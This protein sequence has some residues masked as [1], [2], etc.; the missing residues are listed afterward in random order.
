MTQALRINADGIDGVL[1]CPRCSTSL[2]ESSGQWVC[3]VDGWLSPIPVYET[4]E[5]REPSPQIDE[6]HLGTD[7]GANVR[8][9]RGEGE[10]L[11]ES[12]S[13]HG[14]RASVF[15]ASGGTVPSED[16][17]PF[18]LR[19]GI[20]TFYESK[21]Y[22]QRKLEEFKGRIIGRFSPDKTR[23]LIALFEKEVVLRKKDYHASIRRLMED[24]A[25]D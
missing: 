6:G 24:L 12:G 1:L 23:K 2:V 19:T 10:A 8:E 21:S 14:I 17:L 9:R 15:D 18:Y 11:D 4:T 16:S 5:V 7:L 3:A 20:R 22:E 25:L 13:R